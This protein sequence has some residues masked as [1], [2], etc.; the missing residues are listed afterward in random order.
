MASEKNPV[1]D[2]LTQKKA[3]IYGDVVNGVR[4][5]VRHAVT[6]GRLRPATSMAGGIGRMGGKGLAATGGT[7]AVALAALGVHKLYDAAT[8]TRDFNS[9]LEYAPDVAEM[10]AENPQH[11]NQM[12]STLR[13]FNPD[14]TKDPVVSSSY[15][16][17]MMSDPMSAGGI[18]TEALG[19]RDKMHNPLADKVLNA[20]F[21]QKKK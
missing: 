18:A 12:F 11:V 6:G 8:K 19:H 13:M 3:G 14:F 16:R 7:A 20:A 10:H 1:E 5:G 4:E 15:V 9:M 21:I 2:Y 17:R